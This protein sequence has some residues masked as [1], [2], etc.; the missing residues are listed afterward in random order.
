MALLY[1]DLTRKILEACFEVSNE[2][3]AGFLESVY[4][5]SL[6]IALHQ[7][8][9]QVRSEAPIAVTFRGQN[10]GEFYADLLVEEK[11]IVELKAVSTL[12]K[13][14]I[15]QV[16]NYL[17]ASGM[18]VGLLVNFG[19]PKIEYRRLDRR[20]RNKGKGEASGV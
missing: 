12:A 19:T 17:Y 1:E 10:V 9:L 4:H 20:D 3:G 14:H 6:I 16:I 18:E 8:G 15:A 13:E 11:I 2:L 7:K 5:K